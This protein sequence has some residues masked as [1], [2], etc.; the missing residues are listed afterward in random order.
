MCILNFIT[1]V[2][3]YTEFIQIEGGL[4]KVNVGVQHSKCLMYVKCR[5]GSYKC[6][7]NNRYGKQPPELLLGK[8]SFGPACK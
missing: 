3:Y 8:Y 7:V 2:M 4:I 5:R 6:L 1:V